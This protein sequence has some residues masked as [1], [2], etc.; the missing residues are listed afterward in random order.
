MIA[1]LERFIGRAESGKQTTAALAVLSGGTPAARDAEGRGLLYRTSAGAGRI[2]TAAFELGDAGLNANALMH[3]FWQ[4]ALVDQDQE[5]YSRLFYD[6]NYDASSVSLDSNNVPVKARSMLLSGILIAAGALVLACALW[7]ILKRRDR[8]QWMWL[9][10][11]VLAVAAAG[12]LFLLAGG[13]E[14]NKPMAVIG[15]NLVQDGTGVIRTYS[16]VTAAA[17]TAGR[18]SWGMEGEKLRVLIYDYIDYNEEEEESRAEPVTLRTCYTAGGVNTVTAESKQPWGRI[19]MTSEGSGAV[20]GSVDG[21]AWMEQDG[22]HC[23]IVNGTGLRLAPGHVITNYGYVSMP[24]IGPGEKAEAVLT[25]KQFSDPLEPNYEDGGLYLDNSLSLYAVINAAAGLRYNEEY[26]ADPEKAA[27]S[28]MVNSA[29]EQLRQSKGNFSYGAYE[30][31]LFLYCARPENL[32]EPVL[33]VDGTPVRQT[34]FAALLS[35]E[36]KYASVGRTGVVFRSA[37]MDYPV[38]M[39]IDEE[40]KPAAEMP[41]GGSRD[42]YFPLTDIPTFRFTFSDIGELRIDRLQIVM[43]SYYSRDAEC[44]VLNAGTGEWEVIKV[45]KEL[46]NPQQYLDGEGNLYIQ[47]RPVTTER[48]AEIPTPMIILEGRQAHAEN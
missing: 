33:T 40:L 11:P 42:Y 21:T 10:L 35:T 24:A 36:M 30:S 47:F 17:P 26:S 15:E 48:Y 43:D 31:T 46:A 1:G 9:A 28:A 13:A 41:T 4:Q 32:A 5:L 29:A 2:Y 16:N 23:E 20:E 34:T 22:L 3:Y 14:T 25:K 27:F 19:T 37:G 39:E 45:N 18:H 8:Q 38:R 7:W 44:L 12:C 6:A